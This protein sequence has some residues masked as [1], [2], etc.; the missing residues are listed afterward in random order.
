MSPMV[1]V[2]Y[3]VP[4]LTY[5][6]STPVILNVNLKFQHNFTSSTPLFSLFDEVTI[7][8]PSI[9]C[10]LVRTKYSSVQFQHKI[11]N[12]VGVIFRFYSII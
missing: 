7:I 1:V 11:L 5:S 6:P 10:S 3:L 2:L 12:T 4:N 9:F 8:D